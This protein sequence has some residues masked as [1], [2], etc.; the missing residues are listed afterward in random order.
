MK[1]ISEYG[2]KSSFGFKKKRINLIQTVVTLEEVRN[3]YKRGILPLGLVIAKEDFDKINSSDT[4]EGLE[5][6]KE[7][8]EYYN[9]EE[10]PVSSDSKIY[11]SINE[12]KLESEVE[13][14]LYI[15][16]FIDR[17]K[18]TKYVERIYPSSDILATRLGIVKE[19]TLFQNK[20]KIEIISIDQLLEEAIWEYQRED[21]KH[22]VYTEEEIKKIHDRGH[23]TPYEKA[24]EWNRFGLCAAGDAMGSAA[25][26]CRSFNTCF[27]C[28]FD[29]ACEKEEHEPI[30]FHLNVVNSY[31]PKK[32]EASEDKESVK[33]I[34][35][36]K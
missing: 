34:G 36:I 28:L 1:N 18:K 35:T 24:Q 23:L 3:L 11:L 14:S 9:Q 20:K 12:Q 33:K 2:V 30:T 32:E 15:D 16:E 13:K 19:R 26:R 10:L 4:K 29:Y 27:E 6:L 7:I 21:R 22:R 31:L 17:K 25:N 5:S 8:L